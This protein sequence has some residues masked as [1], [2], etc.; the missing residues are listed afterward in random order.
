MF[1]RKMRL[2]LAVFVAMAVAANVAWAIG[3]QLGETK[4][5]LELDYE[6][7]VKDHGTG[8]VTVKLTIA[9]HGRLEPLSSVNLIIPNDEKKEGSGFVDLSLSLATTKVDDKEVARIHLL[10]ELAERAQIQLR[11]GHLDGKQEVMTWYYHVIPVADYLKK[12]ED[13]RD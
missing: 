7:S 3:F 12:D 8:R 1:S 5:E 6:V 11:T 13:N 4:E 10:K 9:D 2:S